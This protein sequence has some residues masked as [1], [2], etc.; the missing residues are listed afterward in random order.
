M[1]Q[2]GRFRVAALAAGRQ[3]KQRFR[4]R[5][6]TDTKAGKYAVSVCVDVLGQVQ[7]HTKSKSG[8]RSA[9]VVTVAV[10]GVKAYGPTGSEPSPLSGS[11][12]SSSPSG[13]APLSS[14]PATF[15]DSGPSGPV[16]QSNV[17]FT[18][19]GSEAE[20]SFQCSLDGAPWATCA[21]PQQ[22]T[23]LAKGPH[24]FQ[25]RAVNAAG[26]ADL[27][28]ASASFTVEATPP[29]TTITSAPSGRVP[30]GTVSI[31]FS[32]SEEASTFKCSLDK[33]AFQACS[34][35]YKIE[36]PAAGPHT[37][38]VE[39]TNQTGVTGP[40]SA[41]ASWAS[42]EAEHKLC[43]KLSENM[44]IGPE[45][46]QRYI[47]TCD[48][49]VPAHDTLTV[50]PGAII[51]AEDGTQLTVEGSLSAVGTSSSPITFTS[52]NDNSVGGSTGDG[53][54]QAGEWDA[55]TSAGRGSLDLEHVKAGYAEK[56][57]EANGSGT[58]VI[59]GNL[60][61]SE[62]L[63]A[64]SVNGEN[65]PPPTLEDNTAINAGADDSAQP[66]FSIDS[67]SL[68]ADLLG[69]NDAT[70]EGLNVVELTGAISTSSTLA[71]APAAWG[72]HSGLEVPAGVTLTVAPGA[73]IKSFGGSEACFAH[74]VY[75]SIGVQGV[76]VGDGTPTEPI[77]F[78]SVNDDS[79]GDPTGNG[80][81]SPGEWDGIQA[82]GEGVV[83]L[84]HA[85]IS[86]AE[87]GL[88]FA[89]SSGRL[90]DV[91][92]AHNILAI[93]VLHGTLALRGTLVEDQ[94]AI[95]ACAW[96]SESCSVDA[97]FTY[98]GSPEGPFPTGKP[99]FVCGAVTTS[100]YLTAASGEATAEE[101]DLAL[102]NCNGPSPEKA[103]SSA[104]QEYAEAL[105][106]EEISCGGGLK[107]ACE[108]I[109]QMQSCLNA[110]MNLA[111][112]SSP[113]DFNNAS[114][115][116]ATEGAN[117][118]ARLEGR[119]VSALGQVA[120]FALQIVGAGETIIHIANAYRQCLTA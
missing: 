82:S 42:V 118:L 5:V 48:A 63:G 28:P 86:Y 1:V 58:T 78:T 84:E 68:D 76:L 34:S 33:G 74:H 60:F 7:A 103:L 23:G 72:L 15:I 37:F 3:T 115:E 6:P 71:A 119:V 75:C 39:A 105:A 61:T 46:A 44:T 43:G 96:S 19:H 41:P 73:V 83:D 22:Y 107:E 47:I 94:A 54:P 64:V 59:R 17:T 20:D 14:P 49:E 53:A 89:A 2:V 66:A 11:G 100:P 32:S 36:N 67:L 92:L 38:T 77:T 95:H 112:E 51:K 56:A 120:S 50:E 106:G 9:G 16:G 21:S 80:E 8:C 91:A 40:A 93:N 88:A 69:E 99:G 116:I 45:Y 30:I 110:A 35:P 62:G 24:T 65:A 18:F 26:E 29:Q 113:F 31:S 98:W 111:K 87:T 117:W 55:I 57:V 85:D 102:P 52:I 109:K 25:V 114:K 108:M 70:G 12:G 79:V 90:S 81:P 4:L 97:G 27:T 13:S 10:S 104:E 101:S